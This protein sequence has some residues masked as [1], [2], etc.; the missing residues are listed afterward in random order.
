LASVTTLAGFVIKKKE[1]LTFE[2]RPSPSS[3]AFR[4][5]GGILAVRPAVVEVED[6][7]LKVEVQWKVAFV[8]QHIQAGACTDPVHI[9]VPFPSPVGESRVYCA[10]VYD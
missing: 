2:A 4:F 7:K 3:A 9:H 1:D 8:G 5:R 6:E 10:A